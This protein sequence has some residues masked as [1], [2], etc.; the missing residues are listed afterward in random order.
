MLGTKGRIIG[1]KCHKGVTESGIPPVKLRADNWP[2]RN[3][4]GIFEYEGS[5][6]SIFGGRTGFV[7]IYIYMNI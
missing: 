6:C 7:Y 2:R 1:S 5:T 4:A 3:K